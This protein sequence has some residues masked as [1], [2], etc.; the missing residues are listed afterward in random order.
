MKP[1]KVSIECTVYAPG[2]LDFSPAGGCGCEV[3]AVF[4]RDVIVTRSTGVFA[5]ESFARGVAENLK[6]SLEKMDVENE[7]DARHHSH[8][9][10][11][12]QEY[13]DE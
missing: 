8:Q 13:R 6:A 4:S 7:V 1:K 3:V 12:T 5:S 9:S 2:E 10:K 11:A